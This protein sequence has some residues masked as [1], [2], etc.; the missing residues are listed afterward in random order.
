LDPVLELSCAPKRMERRR[1]LA[2]RSSLP[3]SNPYHNE[4]RS[5]DQHTSKMTEQYYGKNCVQLQA[6]VDFAMILTFLFCCTEQERDKIL[7]KMEEKLKSKR[8][9]STMVL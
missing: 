8:M 4:F 3:R 9:S 7:F 6:D 2:F 5:S 1:A